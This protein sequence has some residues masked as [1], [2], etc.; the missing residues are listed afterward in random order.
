VFVVDA[1]Q[2]LKPRKK[3]PPLLVA[4]SDRRPTRL[5]WLGVS[6]GLNSPLF[7][8]WKRSGY[9]PLYIRQ[10]ANDITGEHTTV[11]LKPLDCVG[12]E[13]APAAGWV[14]GFAEDFS[15]RLAALLSFR[16]NTFDPF[17]AYSLLK[18]AIN[19]KTHSSD[20]EAGQQLASL[21]TTHLWF[22]FVPADLKRLDAYARQL[23]DHHLIMDLVPR[24]A[25]MCVPRSVYPLPR[26]SVDKRC[27]FRMVCTTV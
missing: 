18:C 19:N 1:T 16:F 20:S 2:K 22:A 3:T 11:M 17:L 12:M 23:V 10:T 24:L 27:A 25:L 13:E 4:L 5:H 9:V 26:R 6:Y 15:R 14:D 7:R 21:G 8:F